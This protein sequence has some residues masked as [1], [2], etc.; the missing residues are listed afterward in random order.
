MKLL[1]SGEG[2]SD[3]GGRDLG[4]HYIP[5][6]MALILDRLCQRRLEYSL[7]ELA[8]SG[9]DTVQFV[10]KAEL[11][12]DS[13]R[14]Q[15]F[16]RHG[17]SKNAIYHFESARMLGALAQKQTAEGPV[18]AVLFRDADGTQTTPA[19]AFDEKF[20][21]ITNG[22][23]AA[24]FECGVPMVP[25]PKSEAWMLCALKSNPHQACDELENASGNDASPHS[26]KKMLKAAM[27]GAEPTAEAQANAVRDGSLN[28]LHITMPSFTSFRTALDAA[29]DLAMAGSGPAA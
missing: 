29:L 22:F 16:P 7:F 13:S 3:I 21:S 10:A 5:G 28:P 9:A 4:A 19:A 20:Q 26:L 8:E 23:L 27:Q 1:V 11:C 25:R 12:R 6:P 18:I 24:D 14:P 17:Q 15:R 2:K